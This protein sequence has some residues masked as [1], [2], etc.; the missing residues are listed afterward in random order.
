MFRR[1][2][3]FIFPTTTSLL[4]GQK[5]YVL[6]FMLFEWHFSA[7]EKSKGDNVRF[8][9]AKSETLISNR[10]YLSSLIASPGVGRNT[11]HTSEAELQ[12]SL[13]WIN[14]YQWWSKVEEGKKNKVVTVKG[15]KANEYR[16]THWNKNNC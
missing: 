13:E 16:I 4:K 1:T 10:S 11:L 6:E 14:K 5:F 8:S 9:M 2:F 15:Q 3:I 7:V 12:Q